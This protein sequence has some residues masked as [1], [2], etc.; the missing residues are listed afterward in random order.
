[1]AVTFGATAMTTACE[2]GEFFRSK[3]L[4]KASALIDEIK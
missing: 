2:G 3:E 1:M 4:L